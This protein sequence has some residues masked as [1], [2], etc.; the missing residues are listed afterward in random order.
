MKGYTAAGWIKMWRSAVQADM[1]L[2]PHEFKLWVLLQ[3][4]AVHT[5]SRKMDRGSAELSYSVIRVTLRGEDWKAKSY[6]FSTLSKSLARLAETG[7]IERLEPGKGSR[8][9]VRIKVWDLLQHG[10][11]D[12]AHGHAKAGWFKVWRWAVTYEDMDLS[13]EEFKVWYLLLS[14]ASHADSEDAKRT[15]GTIKTT[16]TGLRDTLSNNIYTE[17]TVLRVLEKLEKAGRIERLDDG[18]GKALRMHIR[19]WELM[20]HHD[21]VQARWDAM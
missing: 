18:T 7:R 15:R 21:Y 13:P 16:I 5:T 9:R 17:Q 8:V 1:E 20:Q 14:M 4:I 10:N 12:A 3:A 2:T 11:Y 6:S 19:D